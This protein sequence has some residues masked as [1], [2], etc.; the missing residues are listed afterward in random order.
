[1]RKTEEIV[2]NLY[3]LSLKLD[4]HEYVNC[5]LSITKDHWDVV[6]AGFNL[7]EHRECWEQAAEELNLEFTNLRYIYITHSHP[8]HIGAA[9][10]LQEK[11][12]ATVYMLE[13][14]KDILPL[15]FSEH[16][17]EA[18]SLGF[19]QYG[20][21]K[22]IAEARDLMDPGKLVQ[23]LPR[24]SY[25]QEGDEVQV[26]DYT[27]TVKGTPGHAEGLY[28]LWNEKERILITSDAQVP[29]VFYWPHLAGIHAPFDSNP[30]QTYFQSLEKVAALDA[31]Y[32]LPG[33]GEIFSDLKSKNEEVKHY[34]NNL[35]K[36]TKNELSLESSTSTWDISQELFSP[37]PPDFAMLNTLAILEYIKQETN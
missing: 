17:Q 19:Q 29:M 18:L 20:M 8:D 4:E 15:F 31:I 23:P 10:W 13:K 25:I 14:E 22:E 33:H 35:I 11:S 30:L 2:P 6:D 28:V 27:F 37:Y 34:Y 16:N 21:P 26:G 1:M 3:K 24:V 9:G 36:K 12:S 7:P 32:V 5:Y